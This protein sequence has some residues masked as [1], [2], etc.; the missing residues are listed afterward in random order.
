MN[1][2]SRTQQRLFVPPCVN[3]HNRRHAASCQDITGRRRR[4]CAMSA[5]APA[6]PSQS[7]YYRTWGIPV[8]SV[9]Q[10]PLIVSVSRLVHPLLQMQNEPKACGGKRRISSRNTG[11]ID[12]PATSVV[13]ANWNEAHKNKNW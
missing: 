1:P 4:P 10:A 13:M 5:A 8:S 12:R 6:E 2:F 3:I 7:V 9:R 11:D